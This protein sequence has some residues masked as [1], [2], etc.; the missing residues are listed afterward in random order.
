MKEM[1]RF[2]LRG[3]ERDNIEQERTMKGLIGNERD[4]FRVRKTG[5]KTGM[6]NDMVCIVKSSVYSKDATCNIYI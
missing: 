6:F 4:K 5:Y 2:R 1:D 3:Q